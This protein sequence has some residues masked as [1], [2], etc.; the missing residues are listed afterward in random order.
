M[1]LQT[2]TEEL[3]ARLGYEDLT[4]VVAME[5]KPGS[6]AA[7]AGI[8]AGTLIMEINR[9][10]IRNVREFEQAIETA[11]ADE[12]AMLRVRDEGWTRLLILRLPKK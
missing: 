8:Q 7:D 12:K 11:A 6:P 9:K 3:A 1:T 10:P 2:L 5:V 4:G